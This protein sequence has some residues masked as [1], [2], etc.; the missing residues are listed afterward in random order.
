MMFIGVPQYI[1]TR[2]EISQSTLNNSNEY[3]VQLIAIF[4]SDITYVIT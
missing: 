2:V 3:K 1:F 4:L